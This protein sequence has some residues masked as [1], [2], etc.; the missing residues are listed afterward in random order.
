MRVVH[1]LYTGRSRRESDEGSLCRKQNV[2]EEYQEAF[3][4]K[5]FMDI[6]SIAQGQLINAGITANTTTPSSSPSSSLPYNS[7]HLTEHL[8]EPQQETVTNV[9]QSLE[10]H[11]LLWE[12]F[13]ASLEA[14]HYCDTILEAIQRMRVSYKKIT[15]VLKLSE[16]VLDCPDTDQTHKAIYRDLA[17]FSR[18]KNP[19]SIISS[20]QFRDI[21]NAYARLLHRLKSEDRKIRRR[22]RFKRICKKVGGI[23]LIVLHSAI[24]IGLLVFALHSLVGTVA[25]PCVVVGLVGLFRRRTKR[26]SGRSSTG[27]ERQCE[28][29]DVAAKG[30]YLLINDFDTMSRMVKR[31]EEE[32]DHRQAVAD[33][34]VQNGKC[35]ILKQ[36]LREFHDHESNFLDQLEELEEHIYLCFLTI[37]RSRKLVLQEIMGKQ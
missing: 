25:A 10:M 19:F 23:G 30:I 14:C 32:V 28:Q 36:V 34:C 29:L 2:N 13:E 16:F 5:S 21:H 7:L 1:M 18:Q 6:C 17:S 37:N 27:F 9:T 33:M 26:V 11:H 8:L 4:T 15:R 31:L 3:R 35:E 12:Y 22:G 20:S 24:L